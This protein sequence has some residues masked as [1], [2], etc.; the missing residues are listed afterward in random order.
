MRIKLESEILNIDVRKQLIEE[1]EGA[2]N[3]ARKNEA[4]KRYSCYKDKTSDYVIDML[5]KQF[6][7]STIQEMRYS[8]SNISLVRKVIDKLARVYS[9]G[10]QRSIT[11]DQA[12]TEK[13]GK[14]E[15]ELDLNTAM[16]KTNRFLKLQKNMAVY[17]KPYP[18]YDSAG[19]VLKNCIEL[20]VLNPYLYDVVENYYNRTEPL[21]F[22]L[23]SFRPLAT[24]ASILDGLFRAVPS[25]QGVAG[26]TT[27]GNNRDEKIADSPIDEQAG[28]EKQ[29][30][31]WSKNYHFTCNAQGEFIAGTTPDKVVHGLGLCPII[32]FAIDQDGS[33]WA[34]GGRDL[35]DGAVLIN[36]LL[37]HT[38]HVGVTQGYG[39]F[40]ATGENLPRQFKLGPS[41]AIVAEYKKDEQAEPKFGFLNANPQLD[42]LRSLID[43]YVALLL[44]SNNLSTSGIATQLSGGVSLPSGIALVIDKAESLEDVQDQRQIFIDKEKDILLAVNA[45]L[46][47]YGAAMEDELKD[48]ALP[49]NFEEKYNLRFNDLTPIVSE[50]EKLANL[51]LR[52]DL[53]IDNMIG[54]LMK[55]DPSLTEQQAEEKFKKILEQQIKEKTFMNEQLNAQGLEIVPIQG[56]PALNQDNPPQDPN[57]PGA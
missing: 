23:S 51:K 56:D 2:E 12:A 45:I 52:K 15:S 3:R 19:K 48:N 27:Q 44:T 14:L 43:M 54:L 17:V 46:K 20:D 26:V 9:N 28:E 29:Y 1:I 22:I 30:I 42:S 53:G 37:S 41:K 32:N 25:S 55:D 47:K 6:D 36:A 33:F 13:L 18:E 4:Y 21:A 40:Y 5:L 31:F 16:K 57:A 24:Q 49:E 8:I 50:S 38:A 11:D 39:Q 35:I 7:L 10:V 34:E